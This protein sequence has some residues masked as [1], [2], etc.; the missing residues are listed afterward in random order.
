M[1]VNG[2]VRARWG[3]RGL[4]PDGLCFEHPRMRWGGRAYGVMAAMVA[5]AAA[6]MGVV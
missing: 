5:A 6:V 2:H 3:L 4:E 1:L